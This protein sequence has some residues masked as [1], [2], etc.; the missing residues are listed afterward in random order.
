MYLHNFCASF[1]QEFECTVKLMEVTLQ[2]GPLQKAEQFLS[3]VLNLEKDIKTPGITHVCCG[4]IRVTSDLGNSYITG[5]R[6]V[7]H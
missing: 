7:W 6:D 2:T 3:I 5:T 1:I 4:Y